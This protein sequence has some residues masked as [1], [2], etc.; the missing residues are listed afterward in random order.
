MDSKFAAFVLVALL[1]LISGCTVPDL[2]V[3]GNGVCELGETSKTCPADWLSGSALMGSV[4]A[5]RRVGPMD[6]SLFL[7]MSDVDWPRRFWENGYQVLFEP[8]AQMYHY[9]HRHSR[10]WLGM[11]DAIFN[12]QTHQHIHDALRYFKK[13]GLK[14]FSHV[15]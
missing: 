14:T 4:A 12:R 9:H 7:Y 11:F 1:V 15:Q 10:S 8:S 13:Y 3:C 2:P 6:P 5:A